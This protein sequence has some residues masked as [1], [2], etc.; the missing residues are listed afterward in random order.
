MKWAKSLS[1]S[2]VNVSR[3]ASIRIENDI[4]VETGRDHVS[5]NVMAYE[6]GNDSGSY[7]LFVGTLEACQHFLDELLK[8]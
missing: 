3:M 6:S 1:D 5:H 2:Y 7:L 8:L 4:D